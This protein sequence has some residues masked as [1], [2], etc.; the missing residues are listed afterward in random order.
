MTKN[1]TTFLITEPIV[2]RKLSQYAK[3]INETKI[4]GDSCTGY[5]T[6]NLALNAI[7]N[8]L[9]VIGLKEAGNV[10]IDGKVNRTWIN[11]A[12]NPASTT[13]VKTDFCK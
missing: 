6:L 13:H 11:P 9:A 3:A 4:D 5:S 1:T 8:T 7:I 2:T 12:I 10:K